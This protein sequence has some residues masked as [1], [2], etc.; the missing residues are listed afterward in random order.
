MM[1]K[2]TKMKLLKTF[3]DDRESRHF[4]DTFYEKILE[5]TEIYHIKAAGIIIQN[6][7]K[8]EIDINVLSSLKI[9]EFIE[10]LKEE[11][12]NNKKE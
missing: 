9:D 10:L 8:G 12:T 2:K 7:M 4:T 5:L 11:N 6:I 3:V 1:N